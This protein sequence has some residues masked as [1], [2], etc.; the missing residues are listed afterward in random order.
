MKHVF[1]A[2]S[3]HKL[4]ARAEKSQSLLQRRSEAVCNIDKLLSQPIFN[5]KAKCSVLC[6]VCC[7]DSHKVAVG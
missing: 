5:N 4:L 2:E 6:E 7:D 3:P 1:V